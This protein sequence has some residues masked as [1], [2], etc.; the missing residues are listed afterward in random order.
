MVIE[1]QQQEYYMTI[2]CWHV[3][4]TWTCSFYISYLEFKNNFFFISECFCFFAFMEIVMTVK[5][6]ALHK[7]MCPNTQSYTLKYVN[8]INKVNIKSNSVC[9]GR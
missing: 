6:P 8:G 5:L 9:G 7:Q 3:V 4:V 1:N 2:Q